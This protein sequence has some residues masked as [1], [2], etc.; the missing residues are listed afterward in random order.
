[1]S[2]ARPFVELERAPIE[3]IDGDRGTH[4]PG[5]NELQDEGYCLF[6]SATNVTTSGF[7]FDSCQ[8]IEEQKDR[9]LRKGKLKRK[10]IVMTTRGTLGNIAYYSDDVPFEDV[11]INSGMV[12]FRAVQE[13]LRPEY[14]YYAL[15]SAGTAQQI[16]SLRSGAAQP[17]LPIRDIKKIRIPLPEPGLQD[18]VV[19][20]AKP[21]DDLIG[22][23][24]R[25]IELLEQSARL[26]FKEWFVY[27]RYPGHEHDKVF[28]GVPEGWERTTI[29]DVVRRVPAGQLYSQ[30]TA[31]PE[32]EI[33]IFDQ[34]KNGVIGFHNG[35]PSV[36]ASVE[37]PV[38]V[39]ANHTCYQRVVFDSF[40]AI[41]NVLPFVSS[42]G[43]HRNIFWLHLA[44]EGRV[45][46]SAYKGHWPELMAK[47]II[48]PSQPLAEEFGVLVRN[49]FFLTRTLEK[50][51]V[52]LGQA[53][54]LL[55]PRLMDGRLSV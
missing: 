41:Q 23:N 17:Q 47:E 35:E 39:F 31:L 55:L 28:N 24:Q 21:Y 49:T 36:R 30:A 43:Y 15:R 42:T 44:T 11:R 2:T 13:S 38:I 6:L 37:E 51:N 25:R 1:M 50:Q 18:C 45:Q 4:Y 26:L 9:V 34:A 3:I 5:Q 40:S 19:G 46:T 32:G 12:I 8:F 52:A 33:P 53:R 27:L 22:N 16:N 54:D 10:D 14:L 48:V 20:A 29:K 7:K